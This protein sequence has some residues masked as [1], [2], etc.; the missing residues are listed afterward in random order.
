MWIKKLYYNIQLFFI[1]LFHGFRSADNMMLSSDTSTDNEKG[2]NTEIQNLQDSVYKDLLR[3]EV[4]QEVREL[5]HEMY[6]V[7]RESH[8]YEYVGNGV[9]R[10]KNEIFTLNSDE[11]ENSE[12]FDIQLIQNNVEDT[13]GVGDAFTIENDQRE[14]NIKVTRNIIPKFR[15]EEFTNKLVVKRI[16]K[17]KAQ[18]D[19]YVTKYESQFNRR[20]RPFLNELDRIYQGDKWSNVVDFQG[21]SF[22]TFKAYGADDLKVFEYDNI[23]FDTIIEYKGDYILK[24]VADVHVD[25][26]DIVE[27]FKDETAERKFKNKEKRKDAPEIEYLVAENALNKEDE[28][29]N[30]EVNNLLNFYMGSN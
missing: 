3:G 4:T 13:G 17:E 11:I 10:K 28:N 14:Y 5:R 15:I 16:N 7:E 20:H 29:T 22:V 2:D 25:G 26:Y 9:A 8:K 21:V 19:F 27:E 6:Y 18:L 30:D 1:Y 12:G 23:I 24:F